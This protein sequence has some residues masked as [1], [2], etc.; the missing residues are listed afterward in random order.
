MIPVVPASSAAPR[1]K[2]SDRSHPGVWGN[3]L[4]HAVHRGALLSISRKGNPYAK[5]AAYEKPFLFFDLINEPEIRVPAVRSEC[6]TGVREIGRSQRKSPAGAGLDRQRSRRPQTPTA[7]SAS[8]GAGFSIATARPPSLTSTRSRA[9]SWTS[10]AMRARPMRLSSS[11]C[12]NR[13]SGRA[14]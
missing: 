12:R 7:T 2:D 14:P 1:P 10:P 11:C 4:V 6:R 13:L 3:S 5:G 8:F 9:P